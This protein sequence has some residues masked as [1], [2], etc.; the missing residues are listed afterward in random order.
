MAAKP[1]FEPPLFVGIVGLPDEL[2]RRNALF[3]ARFTM[4]IQV[5]QLPLKLLI[6]VRKLLFYQ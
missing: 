1:R 3:R 4:L 2:R 5:S 6:Q